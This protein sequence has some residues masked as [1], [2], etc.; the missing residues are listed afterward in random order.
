MDNN[1]TSP[2]NNGT[3]LDMDPGLTFTFSEHK[4]TPEAIAVYSVCYT[5]VFLGSVVGN[6]LVVVVIGRTRRMWGVTNFFIFNLAVSDLLIAV[7]CMPFT[8]VGHIFIGTLTDTAPQT[9]PI[10]T[11]QNV[12][13]I[14]VPA[15][16]ESN[17]CKSQGDAVHLQNSD[18]RRSAALSR[19]SLCD[20]KLAR[21][22]IV[23]SPS[24]ALSRRWCDAVPYHRRGGINTPSWRLANPGKLAAGDE[25]RRIFAAG[26]GRRKG[27][28]VSSV[29]TPT[30]GMKVGIS[31][32][33][34]AEPKP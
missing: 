16:Q 18:K 7:F 12:C 30:W 10:H 15:I 34:W 24:S 13:R 11:G 28:L 3:R 32:S 20:L 26:Y 25:A 31:A 21:A 17:L 8:L 14:S 1:E 33:E 9:S 2:A 6:L 22:L 4:Q 5:L 29:G 23:A 19:R 27:R